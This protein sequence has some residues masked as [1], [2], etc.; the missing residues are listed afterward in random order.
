M[1]VQEMIDE[2]LKIPDKDMPVYID[3]DW[4]DLPANALVVQRPVTQ[5]IEELP[6]RVVIAWAG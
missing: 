6:L 4:G 3:Q 2:L 5:G 1:T